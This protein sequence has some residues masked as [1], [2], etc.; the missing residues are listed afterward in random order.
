MESEN[1]KDCKEQDFQRRLIDTEDQFLL[2]LFKMRPNHTFTGMAFQFG[3][4][5]YMLSRVFKKDL[6]D[7]C[8]P[9]IQR[10]HSTDVCRALPGLPKC[11]QQQS[12]WVNKSSH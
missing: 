7:V 1:W 11:F 12:P 2:F 8:L 6:V 5:R 9:K 4:S 3:V 10:Y